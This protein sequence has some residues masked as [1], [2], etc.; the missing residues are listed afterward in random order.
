MPPVPLP[1]RSRFRAIAA[2]LV[3]LL[4]LVPAL[5]FA[6]DP[7]GGFGG[8][9]IAG[10]ITITVI[11]E[12]TGLPLEDA[13]VQVG[14]APSLPFIGNTGRTDTNGSITFVSPDL[15]GPVTVTAGK[16][17][18]SYST[19]V[20][21]DASVVVLPVRPIG[22]SYD[23]PTYSGEITSGFD[24]VW[25]DGKWDAAVVWHTIPIRGLL[26]MIDDLM[27]GSLSRLSPLVIE[28]FPLVGEA[29]IPGAVYVPFQIDLLLYPL[30]RTPYVIFVEDEGPTD[31]WAIY[32]RIS[33]VTVLAELVKPEPDLFNLILGF[34]IR[35][36]GLE[37][38]IQ[39][40]GSGT[41]DFDLTIER[42]ADVWIPVEGGV[43]GVE[44]LVAGVADLDGLA[45][46]GR[47]FPSGFA[48]VPG[49]SQ[50]V[51]GI[52][53]LG[54]GVPGNPDYIFGVVM[55]DTNEVLGNSAVLV[56]AGLAPGDT[57]STPEFLEFS[58]I[59]AADS[60][61]AWSSMANV[62]SGL[63]PDVHEM[64]ISYVRSVEDT[65]PQA[66]P[67][68]TIDIAEVL[69]TFHADGAAT[70]VSIPLLGADAPEVFIDTDLTPDE[71]RH[72]ASIT[73]F[74]IGG[75]PCGFDFDDWD[76][77]DRSRYG[78][79]FAGNVTK[80]IPLPVSPFTSVAGPNGD[81][82]ARPPLLGLPSPNPFR[83]ETTI[84]FC[85]SKPG[86]RPHLA[87]YN[88]LG[89][90]VREL[91]CGIDRGSLT[92]TWDGRDDTGRAVPS[93]I[94]LIRM[95]TEGETI[96]RKVVKTK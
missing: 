93:G 13:Y 10:A 52:P 7:A 38:E 71:D 42:G 4:F 22:A 85:A 32:G 57:A 79:H 66:E 9:P 18:H 6:V 75:A 17:G 83:K 43:P 45:G 44:V 23:R 64:R 69:W 96:T 51:L 39:V 29:D 90:R 24:I 88:V 55:T 16:E 19:A 82:A 95:R 30:E 80:D 76:L 37:E 28:N 5:S 74:L 77:A 36:Y 62:E 61:I 47:L 94:Y 34:D 86:I 31:L 60:L 11:D 46:D 1:S 3:A 68:D 8:G 54:A 40:D 89:R 49:D 72:D 84:R 67:G 59:T 81:E 21:V 25:N 63:F 91:T 33:V 58:T 53:T 65:S 48:A 92:A 78:T 73:G 87:V 70:G 12:L 56:R 35:R 15:A 27:S 2:T 41:Q 50:A 14:P 26:P 20:D